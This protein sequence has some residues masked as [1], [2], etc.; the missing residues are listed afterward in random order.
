MTRPF[1]LVSIS[2]ARFT[3]PMVR[4]WCAS[5]GPVMGQLWASCGP[6]AGRFS[7]ELCR[8]SPAEHTQPHIRLASA[9]LGPH[10]AHSAL[11]GPGTQIARA[12]AHFRP[13]CLAASSSKWGL[14]SGA[15]WLVS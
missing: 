3:G 12:R 9:Q 15:G 5:G 6:V 11:F 8:Q 10:G 2:G 7:R 1:V 4:L 13:V 14:V